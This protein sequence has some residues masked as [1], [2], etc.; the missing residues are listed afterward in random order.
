MHQSGGE[1][2]M[3]LVEAL[4]ALFIMALASTMIVLSMPPRPAPIEVAV[5]R[6][7]DL[8]ETARQS[9]LVKGAWTGIV[10]DN[11]RYQLVTYQDGEWRATRSKP[12]RIEGELEFEIRR[13]RD[14]ASPIFLFGPTGTAREEV[15]TLM[16]GAQERSV[17]VARDGLVEIGGS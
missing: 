11:E 3:T 14:D 6:L 17:R 15:L 2:G 13:Q 12:V 8:A 9:A 10:A 1:S 7:A 5:Y 4:M 16:I